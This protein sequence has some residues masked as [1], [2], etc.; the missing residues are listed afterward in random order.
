MSA[1]GQIYPFTFRSSVE[2]R[3]RELLQANGYIWPYIPHIIRTQMQYILVKSGILDMNSFNI[4]LLAK[5]TSQYTDHPVFALRNILWNIALRSIRW[6]IAFSGRIIMIINSS[7]I[8][9]PCKGRVPSCF[10]ILERNGVQLVSLGQQLGQVGQPP[11]L[12][13]RHNTS[14]LY[15]VSFL[16]SP[17]D[18]S[19]ITQGKNY[20]YAGALKF[21]W[22]IIYIE[23][24]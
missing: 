11:G 23:T 10:L 15:S 22:N 6:N 14:Y 18:P 4:A 19:A 2:L 3:P 17:I 20:I 5:C 8:P 16:F 9:L 21:T 24:H 13:G 12:I 7:S 1:Y